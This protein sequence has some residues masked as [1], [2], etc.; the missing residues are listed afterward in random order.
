MMSKEELT[1]ILEIQ[2]RPFEY[3]SPKESKCIY[4]FPSKS[5]RN[6][7]IIYDEKKNNLELIFDNTIFEY[8]NFGENGNEDVKEML[9]KLFDSMTSITWRL[10]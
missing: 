4:C 8:K 1:D 6:T 2:D 7:E 9:E 5:F 3:Y 10:T